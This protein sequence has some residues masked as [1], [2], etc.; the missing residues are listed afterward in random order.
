MASADLDDVEG[1]G[2]LGDWDIQDPT[3]TTRFLWV[4]HA[5]RVLYLTAKLGRPPLPVIAMG[6]ALLEHY[7][8]DESGRAWEQAAR[9]AYNETMRGLAEKF[10]LPEEEEDL[11]EALGDRASAYAWAWWKAQCLL[12]ARCG[13]T[14]RPALPTGRAAWAAGEDK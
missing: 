6:E 10:G 14:S 1:S 13:V 2:D 9:E 12:A 8:A 3:G 4:R 5:D 11:E 7:S